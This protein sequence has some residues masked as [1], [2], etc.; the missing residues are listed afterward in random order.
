M[1]TG[2]GESVYIVLP[3]IAQR[4]IFKP[5]KDEV[6]GKW[7][8][9][10]NNEFYYLQSSQNI[11]R[12]D[13]EQDGRGTWHVWGTENVHTRFWWGDPRERDHLE[14]PG[15]DGRIILRWIFK[16]L[17]GEAWTGLIRYRIGTSGG[18]L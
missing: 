4:K 14:E 8:K 2:N 17:D 11:I 18:L 1:A 3:E 15:V 13:P 6:T 5:K 10:H 12:G 16:K 9:I 7:I